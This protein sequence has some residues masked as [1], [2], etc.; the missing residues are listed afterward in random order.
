MSYLAAPNFQPREKALPIG[1]IHQ[2]SR[3]FPPPGSPPYPPV[4]AEQRSERRFLPCSAHSYCQRY[5]RQTGCRQ[6][7]R[8]CLVPPSPRPTVAPRSTE[9]RAPDQRSCSKAPGTSPW[10]MPPATTPPSRRYRGDSECRGLGSSCSF[11]E[12]EELRSNNGWE[13]LPFVVLARQIVL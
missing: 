13:D 8:R 9:L 7:G 5:C 12:S 1:I 2:R 6:R 3:R 10:A 11:A 4:V